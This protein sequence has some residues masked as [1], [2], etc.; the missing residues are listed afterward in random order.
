MTTERSVQ[1]AAESGGTQD[2][3]QLHPALQAGSFPG[4]WT[5]VPRT[6]PESLSQP[7][8]PGAVHKINNKKKSLINQ[9]QD[10]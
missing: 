1:A 3:P 10:N 2:E 8:H 7:S 5:L 6:Y 4:N 9:N